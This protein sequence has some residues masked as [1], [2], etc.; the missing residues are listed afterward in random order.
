MNEQIE[1]LW[2]NHNIK[3]NDTTH[4]YIHAPF[5]VGICNY[6]MY[7]AKDLHDCEKGEYDLYWKSLL[8]QI[9]DFKSIL[10][11]LPVNSIYF[12]GGTPSIMPFDVLE[13]IAEII[14]NWEK[15]KVKVF[16]AN[17]MSLTRNKIDILHKLG[18]TYISLGVQT[19][20]KEELKRQNRE[21]PK[22]GH[23]KKITKY[24]LEKG[25]H[26]NYDLMAFI[27]KDNKK[28]SKRVESDLKKIMLNYKPN[29][30]DIYPE[31]RI[32]ANLNSEMRANWVVSLRKAII[33]A[34]FFNKEY[35]I[36]GNDKVIAI[37]NRREM[38]ET[39]EQNY[40][41]LNIPDKVFF[42][43]TKAYSCSG[44]ETAPKEQN[45]IAFGGY[46]GSSIYSYASDRT[47]IYFS[48]IDR[49]GDVIYKIGK[50]DCFG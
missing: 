18:Y 33:R 22:D 47:F 44:P 8:K 30:I 9:K 29:S 2:C 19:L 14:P 45:V 6:C 7:K 50:G 49:S 5:C 15:I 36:A 12:G 1:A 13:E 26:I 17:P 4:I 48:E 42:G 11:I 41:V 25:I 38:D 46:D 31:M 20:D 40:H 32:L 34:V 37:D 35:H 24:A 28:D 23:L 16:E 10:Q 27:N 21:I 39:A 3:E 43:G